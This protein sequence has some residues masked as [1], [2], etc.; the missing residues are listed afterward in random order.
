MLAVEN[1]DLEASIGGP[2]R[3]KLHFVC[4][5]LIPSI[6]SPILW[7]IRISSQSDTLEIV[8]ESAESARRFK[9]DGI[10]NFS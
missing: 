7:H 1:G 10:S 6:M 4:F 9:K 8:Q 3:S 5:A 2:T